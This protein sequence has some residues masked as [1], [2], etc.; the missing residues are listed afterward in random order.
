MATMTVR[1]HAEYD[2]FTSS[3]DLIQQVLAKDMEMKEAGLMGEGPPVI[4]DINQGLGRRFVREFRDV[5][6]GD[7]YGRW[8]EALHGIAA[9]RVW[10]ES[11]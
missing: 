4:I 2:N 11:I 1:R 5:E 10:Y 9:S 7:E 3:T 8:C 6:T